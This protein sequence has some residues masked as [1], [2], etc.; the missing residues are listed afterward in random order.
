MILL[1][2]HGELEISFYL[3]QNVLN[4]VMLVLVLLLMNV[5]NVNQHIHFKME[6]VLIKMNGIL[7]PKNS[8]HLINSL[9]LK[10][11]NFKNKMPLDQILHSHNVVILI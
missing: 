10:V 11:G 9:K 3:L 4:F 1:N 7:H 5:H 2:N 8:L 6:N